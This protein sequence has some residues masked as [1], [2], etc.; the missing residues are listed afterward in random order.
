M[1]C[2]KVIETLPAYLDNAL[3]LGRSVELERHVETCAECRREL[4]QSRE[5]KRN[6]ST[7]AYHRAPD[8][9]RLAIAK[10]L[11]REQAQ[12]V[13]EPSPV[14]RTIFRPAAAGFGLAASMT[15]AFMLGWAL[16]PAASGADT[17]LLDAHLRSLQGEHLTDVASSD[18]HTV[19]PWFNGKLEFAPAVADYDAQGFTLKGGRLDYLNSRPACVLVYQRRRHIINVFIQPVADAE[20]SHA[21]RNGFN[22]QTFQKN[23]LNYWLVSDLNPQELAELGQ[24][25]NTAK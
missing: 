18:R 19:K 5:L 25:L 16:K 11:A 20:F 7:A 15:L 14:K 6:I 3:E 9:L 4:E 24:L 2:A 1:Q 21:S 13:A 22:I 23:G 10:N 8:S 17:E 12:P